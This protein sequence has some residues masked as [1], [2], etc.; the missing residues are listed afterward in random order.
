MIR[1]GVRLKGMKYFLFI[2]CTSLLP[3]ALFAS[4]ELSALRNSERTRLIINLS[5]SVSNYN[6]FNVSCQGTADG[7]ID[8]TPT[9][10]V[11]P[12]TFI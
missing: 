3:A 1:P 11:A 2:F 7:S 9:D 10:G 6:G 4:G 12:Y 5:F 8:L